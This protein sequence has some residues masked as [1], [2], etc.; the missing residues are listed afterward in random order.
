MTVQFHVQFNILNAVYKTWFKL[1][2]FN[3]ELKVR[4]TEKKFG[5]GNL[6]HWNLISEGVGIK[7]LWIKKISKIICGGEQLL[8]MQEYRD[9]QS[10]SPCSIQSE[11]RKMWTKNNSKLTYFSRSCFCNKFTI[12]KLSLLEFSIFCI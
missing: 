12:I 3:L 1:R 10:K 4:N 7:L 5:V 11:C 9:L 2:K 8:K 6:K